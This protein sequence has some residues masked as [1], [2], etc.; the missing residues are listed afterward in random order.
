MEMVIFNNRLIN[1]RYQGWEFN[2]VIDPEILILV[3]NV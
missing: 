3:A 2:G 1:V